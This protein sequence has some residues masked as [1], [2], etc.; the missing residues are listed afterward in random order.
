MANYTKREAREWARGHLRAQWTTL[1]TPFTPEDE[2]DE[3]GLR[4]NI[5][6]I[7]TLGTRGGGCTWGM[8]EFWSLTQAERLRVMDIVSDEANGKWLIAAHV[9]HT[10]HKA[11]LELA[12]HAENRGFDLLIVAPPYM[13]TKTE[14][15]V[16]EYTRLL[17]EN[18]RLAIMFY[19]SPQFGIVMSPPGLKRICE[20][21]NVVGVK[22]ASFNRQLSIETH[23]LLGKQAIISTPDEWIYFEG[24]ERGF[25]QQV[26]FANTS[27]WRFDLPGRNHYVQFVEKASKGEIDTEFYDLYIRPV[28]TVSDKWWSRT[29]QKFGGALPVTLMKEWAELMGMAAGHPRPPLGPFTPE[30]KAELRKDL[31]TVG[32]PVVATT[33]A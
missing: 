17:A 32:H 30:E 10:S 22:E 19:N 14:D 6:H 12:R 23:L 9:T 18:T 3:G 11:M 4:R 29:V 7:R 15:Q 21:P 13:V 26:M 1:I 28:K 25:G 5:R 33:G 31:E 20:V 24:R 16:I 2:V 27:D 8:G